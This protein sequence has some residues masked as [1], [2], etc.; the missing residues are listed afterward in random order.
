MTLKRRIQLDVK[1]SAGNIHECAYSTSW[2][3]VDEL[4]ICSDK[5]LESII[6]KVGDSFAEN[7][8]KLYRTSI[9]FKGEN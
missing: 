1:D 5:L 9:I 2:I 6:N 8:Y 3:E 7:G 4:D